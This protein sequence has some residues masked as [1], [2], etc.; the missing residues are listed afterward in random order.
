MKQL[1]YHKER[2]QNRFSTYNP[3]KGL[4]AGSW[5][6]FV[7]C[8]ISA[9]NPTR[10]LQKEEYLLNRNII[11]NNKTIITDAE[12]LTYVRQKPNRKIV[13]LWRFHLWIYNT[14]NQEKFKPRYEARIEKRKL[15]NEK[16]KAAGKKLKD[17]EPLSLAKWRLTVGEAPVILDTALLNRS[18][19]QIELLLKNHGYFN[20][21]VK[22]SVAFRKNRKFWKNRKNMKNAFFTIEAGT[23]YTIKSI[24][25]DIE[26]PSIRDLVMS[27]KKNSLIAT[28]KN[29]NTDDLDLERVRITEALKNKGYFAFVKNFINYKADSSI[30]SHQVDITLEIENPVKR[31]AGYVDS[32]IS[33]PHVRYK[34]NNI[35]VLADYSLRRDSTESPDTLFFDNIHYITEGKLKFRPRA[36]KPAITFNKGDLYSKIEADKTYRRISDFKTFKFINI[37]FKPSAGGD[38]TG[39][40]DCE[41]QVSP[42]LRNAYTIQTQGTNK[43]GDL[44]V[45]GDFIYQ[46]RNFL[47]GLE[48]IEFR[49]NTTLEVQRIISDVNDENQTIQEFLPFNTILF[50]PVVS[51]KLP[52]IP[53]FMNFLGKSGQKT[54]I[55]TSYNFQQRPD[56]KRNIFNLA[57]GFTA[58]SGTR[59]TNTFNPAE[60]NFVNVN[61]GTEFSA[62]LDKSNNLFLKNSFQS[63]LIS[64]M[65]YSFIYNSQKV[66]ESK[67]FLFFQGNLENSGLVL[68]ATRP[69]FQSPAKN[70]EG[71]YIVFGVPFSQYLR[72]DTD[73]RYYKFMGRSSSIAMRSIVGLGIPYGNS[74]VMPFVKSFFGGGANGNRA[75]IARSLGPGGYQNPTGI[76]FDQIGDIKLEW[77]LEYRSKIYKI[78]E[79]AAFVDAGNIWLRKVDT[80][81]PL[82]DFDLSRFYK[83]IAIGV[84][85]GLRLNFDYFIIR[86]DV[87]Y[88]MRDPAGNA[89]DRWVLKYQKL[90]QGNLNFGIGYPF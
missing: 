80:Q 90:R 45:S 43:A 32:T 62:L 39:L 2:M 60:I 86:L 85:G 19:K 11:I 53:R 58:K 5:I 72:F 3:V 40:L 38:S 82:A 54:N 36:I 79:G 48:Q 12:L 89:G 29:F 63:Q 6:L 67:N 20:A 34:I 17:P 25:Y 44:G 15:L 28:G 65:R 26:D 35:Y 56:Y 10:R 83:E 61:L 69:L 1:K 52:K 22:D 87:A 64:S 77:N 81:R 49:L 66:G 14:V 9:C 50:G 4:I 16:R 41:I 68:S 57:Y 13:G 70:D 18:S 51:L 73:L 46:N 27:D 47:R 76:R 84:G 37:Q 24:T 30:N 78:F 8:L 59:V 71:K 88:K 31:V 21:I 23:P 75:W 74:K 7:L 33:Y 42:Y 55:T